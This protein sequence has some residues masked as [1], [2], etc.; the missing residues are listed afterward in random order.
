MELKMHKQIIGTGVALI[1]PFN[2]DFS[3][4]Y[5]SLEKIVDFV[6]SQGVDFLVALGTTSESATLSTEEKVKVVD[7]ILKINNNRI[8]VVLGMGGND[9]RCL[10]NQI[11]KQ[12]FAGISAIL[13]VTPYYNK[14]QQDGLLAHF[15]AVADASPVPMILYNVPGRTSVNMKAETCLKLAHH[16]NILSVK[17]ASGDMGQ[18]MQII[19]SK[20]DKFELLSG[21]DALTLPMLAVGAKGVI[22]VV[23][24]AFPDLFS[25]MVRFQLAG[26]NASALPIHYKLLR[27]IDLLFVDG[28]PA[29]IK[30]V[31][32]QFGLCSNILRLPLVPVNPTVAEQIKNEMLSIVVL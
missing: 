7:T 3:V 19:A 26:D 9:T 13:S 25:N 6:V 24:N 20:P 16:P 15:R 21:D 14:P 10:I 1:T 32:H 17:E 8:P 22:S 28:N 27:M 23:A 11:N 12:D 5:S 18:V 30:S 2:N 31:L 29:G 4:D